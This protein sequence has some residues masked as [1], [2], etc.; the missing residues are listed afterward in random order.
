MVSKAIQ[1]L[2][3]ITLC[4]GTA[5]A[6]VDFFVKVVGQR[7]VKRTLFYDGNVPI[8]HLY[9]SDELGTPGTVMTTFPVRRAG[10]KGRKGS[11]QFTAIAYS[12]PKGS[13]DF[14]RDHLRSNGVKMLPET[15]RFGSKVIRAEH[16]GIEFEFIEDSAD[17]RDP[18]KSEYVSDKYAVRGFHNWTVAVRDLEDMGHFL[19]DA[20]NFRHVASDGSYSRYEVDQGGAARIVDVHH[21]PDLRQGTW[22]LG[23][24]TVHHG[25]FSVPD[26]DT[27]D[28]LK[29]EVEGMGFTDFS[30][31]KHRGYF[32]SIYVRTPGGPMFEAT[33]SL[34][35]TVDE[36]AETL[37]TD[38]KISPQFESQKAE[39][40]A[41]MT[42]DRI[43][44]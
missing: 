17:V 20:W 33:K 7:F 2:H 18:W 19:K 21:T 4:T 32:E 6:D 37:G 35:F 10:L 15:E 13:G 29:F 34:G 8:Y 38:F 26:Y 36:P 44:I 39:I 12:I 28:R 14:W 3:H 22:T 30:D 25:A 16:A 1:G 24:G 9:F 43:V 40:L 41:S 11:G 5:Q 42:D 31:R 23:E 27:Q